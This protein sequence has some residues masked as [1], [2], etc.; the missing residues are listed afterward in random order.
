MSY[1]YNIASYPSLSQTWW[2]THKTSEH[3]CQY[4]NYGAF[5]PDLPDQKSPINW[6][7]NCMQ[8]K[9][10]LSGIYLKTENWVYKARLHFLT[11][12]KCNRRTVWLL[13]EAKNVNVS[14]HKK[15]VSNTIFQK[16]VVLCNGYNWI[17]L[18]L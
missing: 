17:I 1:Q 18:C 3:L 2:L 14:I 6:S 7:T 11:S 12:W 9:M 8:A 15:P 13:L 4:L 16:Q 10:L 5:C